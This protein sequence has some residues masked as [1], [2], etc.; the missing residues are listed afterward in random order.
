MN[1][2]K[3]AIGKIFSHTT[4]LIA[5]VPAIAASSL[6]SHAADK[7]PFGID[8]YSA[9]HSAGPVGISPDGKTILYD[10][11]TDGLKG[12]TKHEYRLVD[13]NGSN[14][15]KL[16]L[17]EKFRPTGFTK[18]GS[19]WGTYELEP[20]RCSSSL[21][22]MASKVPP[23]RPMACASLW[24]PTRV[25][26]IPSLACTPSSKTKSPVFTLSGWT[27]LVAHGGAPISSPSRT[28]LGPTIPHN[29]P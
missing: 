20:N 3:S 6:A 13:V 29:S 22:R 11:T 19:L 2:V 26:R 5:L 16:D 8:D 17:P 1:R 24:S 4:T 10:V 28:S 27:V 21:S 25:L 23:F 9:L 14:P 15:R 18:D 12:P 7:H